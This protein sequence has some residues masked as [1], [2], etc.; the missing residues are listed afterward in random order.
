M[1]QSAKDKILVITHTVPR[2]DTNSADLRLCSILDILAKENEI[3]L[4]SS[5]YRPGDDAYITLLERCGITVHAYSEQ[6]SLRRLLKSTRFKFAILEYY[7]TAEYFI[8]RI[9]IVQAECRIVVDSVDV[10]YLRL[11]LKYDLTKAEA[12]RDIYL[13]TKDRE[14]AVY[15][16]ADAVITVTRDDA[17]VL[18]EEYPDI[19]YEV[20][21]NIHEVNPIDAAPER[22]TLIFV[23]AFS[24]APNVDAVLYFCGEIL[25]LIKKSK[26]DLRFTI[27]GSNPPE[28]IRMLE[29]ESI[30]VT[31]YVPETSPYLHRS[32]VSVA[33]LRWGAGMKGKIGEAMAHGIPVVTTTVGAQGMGLTDRKNVMIADSPTS[34]ADAVLKLL[35]DGA[36]YSKIRSN[37]IQVIEDNYAPNRVAQTMIA[38]LERI[39]ERPVKSMKLLEKLSFFNNYVS[40]YIKSALLS[41]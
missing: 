9:R 37:A 40:H 10:H 25:P 36:L 8:D 13:Q 33:P 3:C 1:T 24:H 34:F 4:V 16:K 29:N 5:L 21:P 18:L 35:N 15:R 28:Q 39:A 17:A 38:A 32:Q 6:F 26:P 27:I 12:D 30:R 19:R 22:D 2:A 20:V 7:Y 31:G 23:G 41:S 14:L 11:Q